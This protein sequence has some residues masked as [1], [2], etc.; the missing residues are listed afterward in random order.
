MK[1]IE[2]EI[3]LVTVKGY[4]WRWEIGRLL[5]KGYKVSVIQ[6]DYVI[7]IYRT[8]L[9]LTI[10]YCRLK[11]FAEKVDLMLNVVITENKNKEGSIGKFQRSSICLWHRLWR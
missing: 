1:L 4:W 8:K 7:E 3:T 10:L 6:D 2:A 11:I 9:L 5:V